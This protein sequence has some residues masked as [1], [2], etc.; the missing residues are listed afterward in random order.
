MK[1]KDVSAI[2]HLIATDPFLLPNVI[3]DV[4]NPFM[5]GPPKIL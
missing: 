2:L 1:P 4:A 3:D 5:I